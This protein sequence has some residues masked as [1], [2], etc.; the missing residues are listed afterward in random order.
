MLSSDLRLE[1]V[2]GPAPQSPHPLQGV[3]DVLLARDEELPGVLV[4]AQEVGSR[5]A[6]LLPE[7]E[8]S[9]SRDFSNSTRRPL[10]V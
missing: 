5:R 9:L 8:I 4:P 10:W 7:L 3:L 1:L 2:L 6:Q